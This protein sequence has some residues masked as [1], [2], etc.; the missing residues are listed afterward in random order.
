MENNTPTPLA[1]REKDLIAM[2]RIGR[3][4]LWAWVKQKRFPQPV[5]CGKFT[6]WRAPDVQ[7]WLDDLTA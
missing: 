2:L 7:K 5:R 3:S 4:T 1:Y 6:A